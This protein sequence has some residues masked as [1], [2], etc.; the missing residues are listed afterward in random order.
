MRL[1][2]P[3]PLPSRPFKVVARPPPREV[4]DVRST[5][6]DSQDADQHQE[7]SE[8]EYE[9]ASHGKWKKRK[10]SGELRASKKRTSPVDVLPNAGRMGTQSKDTPALS[11]SPTKGG[12]LSP[13][14]VESSGD[15]QD[16]LATTTMH[17]RDGPSE[18]PA[19][20]KGMTSSIYLFQ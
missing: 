14:T 20:T 6:P 12:P 3:P 15:D 7:D 16:L 1:D 2:I 18:Q 19:N 17:L 8:S 11:Q 9:D 5:S 4:I 10:S 13:L